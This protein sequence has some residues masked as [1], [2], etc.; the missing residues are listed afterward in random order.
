M[1]TLPILQDTKSV[2]VKLQLYKLTV[3]KF[4]IINIIYINIIFKINM[5]LYP[6]GVQINVL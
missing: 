3:P 1:H 4:T 6:T 5:I 2:S